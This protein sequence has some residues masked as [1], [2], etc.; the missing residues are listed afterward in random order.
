LFILLLFF[1]I[2]IQKIFFANNFFTPLLYNNFQK[3]F[4]PFGNRRAP[5]TAHGGGSMLISSSFQKI[6][7]GLGVALSPPS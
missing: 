6:R 7:R 4:A 1:T 5:W 3:S 2:I